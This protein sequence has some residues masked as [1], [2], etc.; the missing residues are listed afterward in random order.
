MERQIRLS[1]SPYIQNYKHNS[2]KLRP[3]RTI[4]IG[5]TGQMQNA[6]LREE[7]KFSMPDHV[8]VHSP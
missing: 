8:K 7:W 1:N 3:F 4:V 2:L 6:A 5:Y